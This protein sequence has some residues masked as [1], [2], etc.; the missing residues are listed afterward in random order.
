MRIGIAGLGLV[1]ASIA[2]SLKIN[3]S[4][5]VFGIDKNQD[6]NIK[7]KITR[8][9]DDILEGEL[10]SRC[11]VIFLALNPKDAIDYL[12]ANA[13]RI[14]GDCIVLDCCGTKQYVCSEGAEIA[15]EHGFTF[16]G[17]DPLADGV[18]SGFENSK[19]KLFEGKDIVV[20]TQNDAPLF[21]LEKVSK[22]LTQIGFSNIEMSTP[23]EHDRITA[24]TTQLMRIVAS[25]LVKSDTAAE[26]LGFSDINYE[27]MTHYAGIDE[28]IW[29]ELFLE[30]REN[31]LSELDALIERL[32][33][34]ET[35]LKNNS[36]T[37]TKRLIKEGRERK[38]Y[39]D[40][41]KEFL[42]K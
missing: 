9:I 16:I 7:A 13:E 41:K 27:N 28:N 33:E 20:T 40:N 5:F 18:K 12:R 32:G 6:I 39:L 17:T 1:G 26:H 10:I 4:H 2:K 31:I 23:R 38:E 36:E 42:W 15:K 37:E 22:L 29:T 11:D 34:Y 24:Y 30:N 21:A 35:A 19:H 14:N 3:T 25:A 8:V